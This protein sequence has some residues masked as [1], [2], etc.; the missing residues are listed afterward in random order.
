MPRKRVTT[1]KTGKTAEEDL[2]PSESIKEVR[3]NALKF[4]TIAEDDPVWEGSELGNVPHAAFVRL[5]P[6]PNA[7]DETIARVKAFFPYARVRTLPRR[8]AQVVTEQKKSK[9]TY[10]TIRATV[11]IMVEEANTRDREA[12]KKLTESTLVEVGL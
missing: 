6:P 12:L 9:P 3:I 7:T 5:R 8:K 11:L 4:L 2:F 1:K 10:Q